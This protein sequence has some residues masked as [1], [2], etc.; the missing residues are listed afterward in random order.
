MVKSTGFTVK[1]SGFRFFHFPDNQFHRVML[2][3]KENVQNA[4]L[5]WWLALSEC[6]VNN[7]SLS[8]LLSHG[9]LF[10]SY[11]PGIYHY[12]YSVSDLF[13]RYDEIENKVFQNQ[14]DYT[15]KV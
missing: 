5:I 10:Y 2:R 13:L 12:F 8:L 15:R 1:R 9:I 11:F 6:L 4:L 14:Y 7:I 3:N